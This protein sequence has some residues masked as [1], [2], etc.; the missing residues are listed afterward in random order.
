M[1]A[2]ARTTRPD[3]PARP[4]Q[5]VG[6]AKHKARAAKRQAAMSAA[7][8]EIGSIPK[9]ANPRRRAKAKRS[10]RCFCETYLAD[11]FKLAWSADHLVVIGKIE[12]AVRDGGL[13]AQAMPRG[14]GKTSLAEAA[15]L[16][17]ILFGY[18]R[19]VALVGAD[20]GSSAERLESIKITL[21]TNDLL[22]ADFP[23]A[24]LPVRAL[25]RIT[26]RCK[27]Q[28]CDGRPTYI[29]WTAHTIRLP[30]VPGHQPGAVLRTAGITGRIRGMNFKTPTGETIRPDLAI[31]DDPQTDESAR[32]ASQTRDREAIISGA[33]LG[34]AGPGRKIAAIMPCTVITDND[35]ADRMLDREKHPDWRGERTKLIYE[36]PKGPE[37]EACW[38]EYGKIWAADMAADRGLKRAT[39]YYRKHRAVMDEGAKVAWPQRKNDDELSALQNAYNLKLQGEEAF[40]AEYQNEPLPPARDVD[41]PRLEAKS[42]EDRRHG[43][44]RRA[45]PP[46]TSRLTAFVD[47]QKQAL[48]YVVTAWT[49]QTTGYVVDYGTMPEQT[50]DF[51]SY[52]SIRRTLELE[53]PR[54]TLEGRLAAGIRSLSAYLF[55]DNWEGHK[56][57]LALVDANWGESRN[58]VYAVCRQLPYRIFPSHGKFIG[59][60]SR[61]LGEYSGRATSGYYWRIPLQQNSREVR[62][63]LYDTNFWKTT[64]AERLMMELGDP[65]AVAFYAARRHRML[66]DQLTSELPIKVEALGRTV[67][68]WKQK[69]DRR[70]NH[71]WDCLVGCQVAGSIAGIPFHIPPGRPPGSDMTSR[72]GSS[73]PKKPRKKRVTYL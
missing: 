72:E 68:E 2:P 17:A 32:S 67:F 15:A 21:E 65:G 53:F 31:I 18:R 55:G 27:G 70:D 62:H 22:A 47:V 57:D 25:E 11:V 38:A 60:A 3:G 10:F 43:Y 49:E 13:F 7:A 71:F 1:F 6:Y 41:V 23:E 20:E 73:S 50:E 48:Y 39:A 37:A 51:F 5:D 45:I 56:L 42:L 16:W 26:N 61:P 33:I 14:S 59:A 24:C 64:L 29:H 9:P 58:C 36:W 28:T 35:L 44:M 46:D 63:V 30:T 12:T 54:G 69:P 4:A 19:Y 52:R 66:A 8:R 40:A 34:L